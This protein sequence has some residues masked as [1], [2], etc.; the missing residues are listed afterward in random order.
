MS[1]TILVQVQSE[2]SMFVIYQKNPNIQLTI[3]YNKEKHKM[4]TE[5]LE[6]ENIWHFS[7]K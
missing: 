3:I 2:E 4:C 5:R 7:L 1:V 6:P